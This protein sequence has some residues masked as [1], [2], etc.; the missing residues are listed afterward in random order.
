VRIREPIGFFL[1]ACILN[2]SPVIAQEKVAAADDQEVV[3]H[4]LG[5]L[6]QATQIFEQSKPPEEFQFFAQ[7]GSVWDAATPELAIGAARVD[8]F[9]L[10]LRAT[11][12]L[13]VEPPRSRTIGVSA[14]TFMQKGNL[15]RAYDLIE[16]TGV[17]P[18]FSGELGVI[19][20]LKAYGELAVAQSVAG[21]IGGANG[22]LLRMQER[23][24]KQ[25]YS[26]EIDDA[27]RDIAVAVTTSPAK[28]GN[29]GSALQFAD[30]ITDASD[31]GI[32]L[33]AIALAQFESGDRTAAV[34]TL[35]RAGHAIDSIREAN[36][37]LKVDKGSG[38][39]ALASAHARTGDVA[40]AFAI[41]KRLPR[42]RMAW[43]PTPSMGLAAIAYEQARAG[44]TA[45][46]L[47][48]LR[49]VSLDYKLGVLQSVARWQVRNHRNAAALPICEAMS[50]SLSALNPKELASEG[51]N[52]NSPADFL[53]SVAM[54]F[55]AAG[56]SNLRDKAIERGLTKA[57]QTE[58]AIRDRALSSIAEAQAESGDFEAAMKTTRMIAAEAPGKRNIAIA[59]IA[60]AQAENKQFADSLR[61][62][63]AADCPG[64]SDNRHCGHESGDFLKVARTVARLGDD[65]D[66]TTWAS[67]QASSIVKAAALALVAQG[68]LDRVDGEDYATMHKRE[69]ESDD[70]QLELESWL[71]EMHWR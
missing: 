28:P 31:K 27:R 43:V 26:K 71:P 11:A 6:R 49:G 32:A 18:Q 59:S 68:L 41:I 33:I 20:G 57:N 65:K 63:A 15:K 67:G 62:L 54:C 21:D 48:T 35:E 40:G 39:I 9:E 69:R 23:A 44:D 7:D 4:A 70:R 61:T 14:I 8:D 34:S 1:A 16:R 46:A 3:A 13:Y 36:P 66:A 2:V 47:V 58:N 42:D 64:A 55:G 19:Y 25:Q 38:L 17:Q 45:S 60:E 51:D 22:T 53:A 52:H 50:D 37:E 30:S 10:C 12:E 5:L 29:I 56:D 24:R